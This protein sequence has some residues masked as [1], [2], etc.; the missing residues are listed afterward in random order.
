MTAGL[1]AFNPIHVADIGHAFQRRRAEGRM[2]VGWDVLLKDAC[3]A[4]LQPLR[5]DYRSLLLPGVRMLE[6]R[7]ATEGRTT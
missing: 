7:R 2:S 6:W 3:E 5:A 4:D 1:G